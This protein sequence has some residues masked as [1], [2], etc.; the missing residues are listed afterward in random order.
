MIA[1]GQGGLIDS[2]SEQIVVAAGRRFVPQAGIQSRSDL[3]FK[4]NDE[5]GALGSQGAPQGEESA[6]SDEMI[7]WALVVAEKRRNGELLQH[8]IGYQNFLG[9]DYLVSRDTLI[10]RPET[11]ILVTEVLKE[12]E[13]RASVGSGQ[14]LGFEVGIGTGVISI[15]LLAH[16]AKT[17]KADA[18]RMIGTDLSASVLDLA[19]RNSERIL[20]QRALEEGQ[21]RLVC[22]TGGSEVFESFEKEGSGRRL[23][24]FVV[25]NPPYL[26]PGDVEADVIGH[27]PHSAL[28]AADSARPDYFYEVIAEQAARFL[29]PGGF[30]AVEIPHERAA[31][32]QGFFSAGGWQCR[33]VE[34][35]TRRP[36]VLVCHAS[37]RE[38]RQ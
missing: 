25:S 1:G 3:Y 26:E 35:L 2:E 10:P 34:D 14:C 21:L 22:V 4:L 7:S 6:T 17:G 19:G 24:D 16:F 30:V 38:G 18:L 32:I 37:S 9:N 33:V 27:E 12:L 15:E 29:K 28:F 5:I 8:L 31:K 20:G 23:L 36:R 11:E 13:S